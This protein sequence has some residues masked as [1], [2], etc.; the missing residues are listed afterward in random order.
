MLSRALGGKRKRGKERVTHR[1]FA[2]KYFLCTSKRQFN[3][4]Q[5]FSLK[6]CTCLS[7]KRKLLVCKSQI[8]FSV[9]FE[10]I[11][12][13]EGA[14]FFETPCIYIY[15]Y[16]SRL[17]VST[18]SCMKVYSAFTLLSRQ[19]YFTD[20][21]SRSFTPYVIQT[22][23]I[24]PKNHAVLVAIIIWLTRSPSKRGDC[25]FTVKVSK[26]PLVV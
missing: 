2:K 18:V 3:V 19:G 23:G 1:N 13:I 5:S 25:F 12:K 8:L 14:I 6:F 15:I 9:G 7:H 4:S 11:T 17:L 10:I 22:I 24:Q 21:L 20:K 26:H 16:K